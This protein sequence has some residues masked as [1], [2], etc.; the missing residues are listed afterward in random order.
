MRAVAIDIKDIPVLEILEPKQDGSDLPARVRDL[1]EEFKATHGRNPRHVQ[2][3][4]AE[5]QELQRL[6]MTET[7]IP[8]QQIQDRLPWIRVY[9]LKV[10]CYS[11]ESWLEVC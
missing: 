10:I 9:G 5:Q 3:G 4:R 7:K 11:A 2:L 6:L 8:A 1:A